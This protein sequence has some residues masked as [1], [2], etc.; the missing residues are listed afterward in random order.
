MSVAARKCL[1][2]S[3]CPSLVWTEKPWEVIPAETEL[4]LEM[5]FMTDVYVCTYAKKRMYLPALFRAGFKSEELQRKCAAIK[6][7]EYAAGR[8]VWHIYSFNQHAH[9]RRPQ[10]MKIFRFWIAANRKNYFSSQDDMKTHENRPATRQVKL[11]WKPPA[12]EQIPHLPL[13]QSVCA[14]LKL[15]LTIPWDANA[16]CTGAPVI[17]KAGFFQLLLPKAQPPPLA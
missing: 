8:R 7:R 5:L 6:E 15:G 4:H 17:Q 12:L 2:E 11:Y 16:S 9:Q 14:E 13:S 3:T 1:T 10:S